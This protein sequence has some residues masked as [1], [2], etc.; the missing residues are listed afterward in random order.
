MKILKDENKVLADRLNKELP[1][2]ETR[3]A[4]ELSVFQ[5]Q[6]IHYKKTIE[7]L[8]LELMNHAE[9][10][11]IAQSEVHLYKTKLD[12]L[13]F[14]AENE[15]R[16]QSL[17]FQKEKELLNEQIKLHKIQLE[18]ITSKHI[19][20]MSILESK[21]SIERSLEQALSNA[22]TLKQENDS[23]KFK[24]DDLSY[25]YSAAQ[26][27]IENGQVHERT[28][29]GRIFELERSLS[30]FDATS[31]STVS[32]LG[33]TMYK[34]LDE[35][36]IQ[37]QMTKQKLEEK[38]EMEKLLI[39]K[40]HTLEEEICE[41]RDELEQANLAKKAYEKQLKDMKNTCDKLQQEIASSKQSNRITFD[42]PIQEYAE[43]SPMNV[44]ND[45]M[46]RLQDQQKEIESL[47]LLMEQKE[48][49]NTKCKKD[50]AEMTEKAKKL[51]SQCDQLRG[52]LAHAW[53][54]CAEFEER[55]NQT[56][57]MSD[58]SKVNTSLNTTLSSKHQKTNES[59]DDSA[60]DHSAAD[61]KRTLESHN[62]SASTLV[63]NSYL[64]NDNENLYKEL[65][66]ILDGES[67]LD[68]VKFKLR[69]YYT[70]CEKIATENT[71]KDNTSLQKRQESADSLQ[72]SLDNLRME[73]ELLGQEI[74]GMM[75]RCKEE[76]QSVKAE[77]AKE[78][79]RLHLLLQNLKA[80]QFQLYFIFLCCSQY[81]FYG[82]IFLHLFKLHFL[83]FKDG[84]ARLN[85]LKSELEARHAK[86]MEELRTYF[87]RKCLQMEKQ[88]SE[89]I[90]SQ[91]S[92]R[93]S[94]NDSET[95]ELTDD[96]YFGGGGDCLNVSNSRAATPSA[97]DESSKNKILE[98]H[99]HLE[100]DFESTL[101]T[102]RQELEYKVNENQK[103]KAS[104]EKALEEQ[105]EMYEC[106]IRDIEAKLE[107]ST[108]STVQQVRINASLLMNLFCNT[109][110]L[111]RQ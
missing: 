2:L 25:R 54:Q 22:S 43:S 91:Q 21:E 86:E 69:R 47:K 52:G 94:D 53:A 70:L 60:S 62:T 77:S 64:K 111:L 26:S 6:L 17:H 107:R 61:Q 92:K 95:E 100:S 83:F 79:D 12:E 98:D 55:L 108:S 13:R 72:R 81:F 24:L 18:E 49:E 16:M 110:D 88:Y 104:Y 59:L 73:R 39:E 15:R 31:I 50:L 74:E 66:Q 7:A 42:D 3:H 106:Q 8:K 9:S 58:S 32:E 96:L 75:N 71:S 109:S 78:I 41:T 67:N 76:L 34:T 37:N 48:T 45:S 84:D 4:K 87:E 1:N 20:T 51:E 90:F 40:I 101:R 29:S 65:Q 82:T 63:D 10:Q 99:T 44:D 89:E 46:R 5:T 19:A 33:E 14:E 68:E 27:M 105:K 57:V 80:S 38:T 56:L 36:V 97:L 35:E 102:L 11:K 23:L 28:L 85:D 103:N 30:R 93:I